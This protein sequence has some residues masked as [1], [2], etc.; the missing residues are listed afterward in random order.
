M[1]RNKKNYG[2]P[3]SNVP[4]GGHCGGKI[5]CESTQQSWMRNANAA[6]ATL[7]GRLAH[8]SAD[9]IKKKNARIKNH[10]QNASSFLLSYKVD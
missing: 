7:V 1:A 10:Q 9:S 4:A 3:L 5:E 8:N 6:A 2:R